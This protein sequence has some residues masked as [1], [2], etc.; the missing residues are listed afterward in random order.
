M[1]LFAL[2]LDITSTTIVGW[3]ADNDD[4]RPENDDYLEI[5]ERLNA[6]L[7][8]GPWL[9][10]LRLDTATFLGEPVPDLEDRYR[11]EKAWVGF[12]GRELEAAAGDSY[13]S[14]GRGLAL[15]LRKI[16]ELGVDTTVRGAKLLVR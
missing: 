1:I 3:H 5:Y 4:G 7:A 13:V 15:S 14:F 16:D 2:A 8:R 9:A 10:G 6:Q 12:V 11:P